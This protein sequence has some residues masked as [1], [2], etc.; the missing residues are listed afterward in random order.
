MRIASASSVARLSC[1]AAV[2]YNTYWVRF[3]ARI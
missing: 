2:L 1:G 3:N